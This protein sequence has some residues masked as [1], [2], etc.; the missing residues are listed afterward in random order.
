MTKYRARS[1]LMR[2]TANTDIEAR[3]EGK[4]G[5]DALRSVPDGIFCSCR[6]AVLG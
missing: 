4:S 2:M 5:L 3:D 1:G 6:E